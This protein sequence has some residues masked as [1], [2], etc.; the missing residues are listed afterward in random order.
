MNTADEILS[1]SF[2]SKHAILVH[3][4]FFKEEFMATLA[5]LKN[6]LE[7]KKAKVAKLTEQLKD[8]KAQLA[9]IK[10]QIKAAK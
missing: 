5:Q 9:D 4:Y 2:A 6:K 10:E 7:Q 8:E 1:C 3:K